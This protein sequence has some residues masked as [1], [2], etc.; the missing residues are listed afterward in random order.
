MK[1]ILT[2]LILLL[3]SNVFGQLSIGVGPTF[4]YNRNQNFNEFRDK[5]N[6]LNAPSISKKMGKANGHKGLTLEV[7]FR[8]G[9]LSSGVTRTYINS[10]A[11]AKLTNGTERL[12]EIDRKFTNA[13]IGGA[14]NIG[15]S[16]E[17]RIEIGMLHVVSNMYSYVEL[18][19]GE[20]DRFTGAASH[21]STWTNIGLA[22]RVSFIHSI[23]DRLSYYGNFS[24]ARSNAQ[25]L[26]L[27]PNLAYFDTNVTH[28]FQGFLISVGIG[29]NLSE[30]I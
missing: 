2:F 7:N 5:Y 9:G 10:H 21:Q 27:A 19:T 15:E 29:F 16:N 8:V 4:G 30:K 1:S 22:G 13:L 12:F 11:K 18:P 17:I 20:V 28:T 3:C 6:E 14:F 25:D 26:E 24:L 23:T